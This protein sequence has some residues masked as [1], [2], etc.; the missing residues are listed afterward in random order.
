M[1][2]DSVGAWFFWYHLSS[3][4]YGSG[5]VIWSGRTWFRDAL[6]KENAHNLKADEFWNAAI[7]LRQGY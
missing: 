1:N 6:R 3:I 7:K 5:I 2:V 4:C